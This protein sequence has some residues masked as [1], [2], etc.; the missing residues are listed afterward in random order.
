[1]GKKHLFSCLKATA[2]VTMLGACSL[3]E[4]S[5]KLACPNSEGQSRYIRGDC[6]TVKS[7]EVFST[8]DKE[9]FDGALTGYAWDGATDSILLGAAAGSHGAEERWRISASINSSGAERIIVVKMDPGVK[10]G[11]TVRITKDQLLWK[12]DQ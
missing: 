2:F 1:M 12:S 7:V 5:S 9:M 6:A 11:Q 10:P 4:T 3:D 8:K